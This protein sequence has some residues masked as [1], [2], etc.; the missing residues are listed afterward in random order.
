MKNREKIIAREKIKYLK[1]IDKK[2][3]YDKKYY[4][5]NKRKRIEQHKEWVSENRERVRVLNNSRKRRIKKAE[6]EGYREE[7]IEIYEKCPKGYHV[8]HIA[9]I[10][11]PNLCGLHVPWNLQYLTAE[12]NLKKGNKYGK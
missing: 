3:E 7:I 9:P 2:K 4:K 8:D 6:L 10:N 5:A 11:H 1:N 12:E